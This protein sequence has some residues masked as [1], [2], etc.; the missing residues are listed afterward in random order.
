MAL[1]YRAVWDDLSA[2]PVAV[3]D[4][5]F[6]NWCEWK[7]VDPDDVPYRGDHATEDDI[8]IE[9][10]RGEAAYGRVLQC[11]LREVDQWERTWTTTATAMADTRVNT[12]WVD[13][14]CYDPHDR[15]VEMAAP[16][17]VRGLIQNGGE[18]TSFGLPLRVDA[19][20]INPEN[21]P[22]LIE[23]LLDPERRAP[24]VVFSPH[25]DDG[26][27]LTLQRAD[28]AA[29]ALAGVAHVFSFSPAAT[30]AID[31]ALPP[32]FRVYGGAVR[33]YLPGV[34]VED[35]D[36]AQRHR[37]I[38][39]QVIMAHP[40]R[41]ASLLAARLARLQLHQPIPEVWENLRDLLRQPSRREIGERAAAISNRRPD[42]DQDI[43]A[44]RKEI[45]DLTDLL[46]ASQLLQASTEREL[47][48]VTERLEQTI[49]REEARSYDDADEL[50]VLREERDALQRNLSQLR[51]D[52]V[53][54]VEDR[55]LDRHELPVPETVEAAVEQAR[56]H[57]SNVAI[58]DGA[59]RDIDELSTAPKYKVWG[60][61]V[62]Q[63]LMALHGYV[64]AKR[65]GQRPAGFFR[66]CADTNAWPPT[67]LAMTES[68]TVE[69]SP[70]LRKQRL[71]PVSPDVD[72]SGRIYMFRHMK[73]QV[74]GGDNIPRLYFHDDT[75][76][77][78]GVMHVGFI[79]PHRYV[80]NTKS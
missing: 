45:Q 23:P 66:W 38:P 17:L 9:V 44:L 70:K 36:D 8:A 42:L 18:P 68:D 15:P 3:L 14:D 11:Q 56:E 39:R 22:D 59:L 1:V 19:R 50:E 37:W 74:G 73:I 63:A 2:E 48:T 71:F 51:F 78:T 20:R 6:K 35:P 47:T 72:P 27:E 7:G 57:L 61:A 10:R 52:G 12:F 32:S 69:Q 77:L 13:L 43:A 75:D 21:A 79:G 29:E 30:R 5:E 34:R 49:A 40:R 62:W 60:S 55:V 76:G 65:R 24:F 16:R 64:E 53:A 31:T 80:R 41:A 4:D 46:A 26:P 54:A 25:R 28:A 33:L 58:P 67:K